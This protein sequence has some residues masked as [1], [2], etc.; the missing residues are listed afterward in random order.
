MVRTEVARVAD[1]I[2][3]VPHDG[4][5]PID[6][7]HLARYTC[8]NTVLEHEV[9]GLFAEHA[10][11]YLASLQSGQ[12]VK[13]R[14]DAAHTLKGSAAAVG[15]YRVAELAQMAETAAGE[16]EAA[17]WTSAIA[18]LEDAVS[19]VRCYIAALAATH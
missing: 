14:R 2:T 19:D 12:T 17:A 4:E 18:R 15:A 16:P 7:V 8:G 10:P 9:L 13:L 6:H 11:L 5:A 3:P 1:K